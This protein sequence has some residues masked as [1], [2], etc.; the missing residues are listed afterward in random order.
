MNVRKIAAAA[1]AALMVVGAAGPATARTRRPHRRPAVVT[2]SWDRHGVIDVRPPQRMDVRMNGTARRLFPTIP[3]MVDACATMGGTL[4]EST[5]G[6][7]QTCA[8]VDY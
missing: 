7:D 5:D 3:A 2:V 4:V 6:L 8:G 1:A